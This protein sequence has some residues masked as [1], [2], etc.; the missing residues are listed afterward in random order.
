MWI[1][2]PQDTNLKFGSM[3]GS[4]SLS[5]YTYRLQVEDDLKLTAFSQHF[6]QFLRHRFQYV[7]KMFIQTL[8][9][10]FHSQQ[11]LCHLLYCKNLI[12]C[13]KAQLIITP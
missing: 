8:S 6:V 3:I 9:D 4:M 5:T 2:A 1:V 11:Q 13:Q 12:Y 7:K 10:I